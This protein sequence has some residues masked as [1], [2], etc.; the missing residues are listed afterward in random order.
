MSQFGFEFPLIDF[1]YVINNKLNDFHQY[2][3]V[4]FV[5]SNELFQ[6][7]ISVFMYNVTIWGPGVARVSV[8]LF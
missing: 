4:I 7:F 5:L 3:L 2:Q 6:L 8:N 1:S